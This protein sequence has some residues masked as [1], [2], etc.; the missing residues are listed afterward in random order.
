MVQHFLMVGGGRDRTS[1]S[2]IRIASRLADPDPRRR[3]PR[4]GYVTSLFARKIVAAAGDGIN[5]S[6][7]LSSVGIDPES[8]WDSGQM[9]PAERNYDMLERMTNTAR[10]GSPSRRRQRS[11]HPTRGSSAM[12]GSGPA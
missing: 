1:P 3:L 8:A 5:A 9:I 2:D 10:W 6:E 7:M 4:M 12:P 11:A